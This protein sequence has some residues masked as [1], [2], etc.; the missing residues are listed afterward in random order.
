MD[1]IK[2]ATKPHAEIPIFSTAQFELSHPNEMAGISPWEI[3]FQQIEAG[4]MRVKLALFG[5]ENLTLTS[6]RLDRAVYQRGAPPSDCLTFGITDHN[7]IDSWQGS[8]ITE[9][10]LLMFGFGQE[11]E[12]HTLSGHAGSTV[13]INKSYL[14]ALADVHDFNFTDGCEHS[15]AIIAR[16]SRATLTGLTNLI[17]STIRSGP[18]EDVSLITEE[19]AFAL[20]HVLEDQELEFE[21]VNPK[22]RDAILRR[23]LDRMYEKNGERMSITELCRDTCIPWRTLNRAFREQFGM[24]PKAFYSHFRLNRVRYDLIRRNE[25]ETVT[26]IANKYDYWHMGQFAKDYRLLFRELPSVTL[27]RLSPRKQYEVFSLENGL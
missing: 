3:D 12:S 13:S 21:K 2:N 1:N 27:Q 8:E 6:H 20:L 26:E 16:K 4:Q 15:R 5:T 23:A 9:N 22:Y 10:T 11:F 17:S 25:N 18:T 24:G 14:D 7:T 19:I